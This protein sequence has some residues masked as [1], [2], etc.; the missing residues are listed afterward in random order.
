MGV[1]QSQLK[2]WGLA[3][4][5]SCTHSPRGHISPKELGPRRSQR[6]DP[7]GQALFL[8]QWGWRVQLLRLDQAA[9]DACGRRACPRRDHHPQAI[10]TAPSHGSSPGINHEAHQEPRRTGRSG[11]D[12][13]PSQGQEKWVPDLCNTHPVWTGLA[14]GLMLSEVSVAGLLGIRESSSYSLDPCRGEKGPPVSYL[15]PRIPKHVPT[16]SSAAGRNRFREM[17]SDPQRNMASPSGSLLAS[18]PLLGA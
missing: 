16:S 10:M 12:W 7:A 11:H 6:N 3:G 8:T 13:L 1:L 9:G 15:A 18:C 2:W 17:N 5:T 14:T 4:D